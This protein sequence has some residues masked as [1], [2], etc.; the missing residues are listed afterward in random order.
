MRID[1]IDNGDD[2]DDDNDDND[3]DDD[4]TYQHGGPEVIH[5]PELR[6]EDMPIYQS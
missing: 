5:L 1:I 6:D 3:Y 4:D 2:D